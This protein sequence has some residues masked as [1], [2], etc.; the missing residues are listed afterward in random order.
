MEESE[1][2]LERVLAMARRE[3]DVR[4]EAS[5][6]GSLA[7]VAERRG[8]LP[9]A[10]SMNRESLRLH[11][12]SGE[13]RFQGVELNHQGRLC[14]RI[15]DPEAA[16]RSLEEAVAIARE[17]GERRL[18]SAALGN[19]AFLLLRTGGDPQRARALLE[20]AEAALVG[21]DETPDHGILACLMGHVELATGGDGAVCL[22]RARRLAG[23]F[24]HGSGL[25]RDVATL[26]RAR[27]ALRD[28]QRLVGGYCASDLEPPEVAWLE[29]HRPEAVSEG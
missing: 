3:D 20:E 26:E 16:R 11:Q 4:L 13:R 9:R 12:R 17:I 23:V 8:D 29:R 24:G 27:A 1:A 25:A 7:L 2:L 28:G 5:V 22:E 6:V 14:Q 19:L 18:E 10:L 21:L 15:G